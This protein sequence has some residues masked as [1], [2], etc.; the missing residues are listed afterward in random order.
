MKHAKYACSGLGSRLQSRV[1][2]GRANI[3]HTQGMLSCYLQAVAF[4]IKGKI[5]M[6]K[7]WQKCQLPGRGS[8]KKTPIAAS[9]LCPSLLLLSNAHFSP[10]QLKSRHVEIVYSFL[11]CLHSIFHSS[12]SHICTHCITNATPVVSPTWTTSLPTFST[13]LPSFGQHSSLSAHIYRLIHIKYIKRCILY[14]ACMYT[15]IYLIEMI[16]LFRCKNAYTHRNWLK[17]CP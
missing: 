10:H 6:G 4:M 17:E 16:H 15:H 9:Y 3:L 5:K 12:Y 14:I 11:R 1:G 13:F 8:I 2:H 7:V